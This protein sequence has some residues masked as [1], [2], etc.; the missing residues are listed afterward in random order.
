MATTTTWLVPE[1]WQSEPWYWRFSAVSHE[2]LVQKLVFFKVPAVV[3]L[4]K[5]GHGW[6]VVLRFTG[7]AETEVASLRVHVT[8]CPNEMQ[9]YMDQG[10]NSSGAVMICGRSDRTIVHMM[11]QLGS[12]FFGLHSRA[13]LGQSKPNLDRLLLEMGGYATTLRK[14]RACTNEL[15]WQ[16]MRRSCTPA[17]VLYGNNVCTDCMP[18]WLTYTKPTFPLP[19]KPV[20]QKVRPPRDPDDLITHMV[21]KLLNQTVQGLKNV[22]ARLDRLETHVKQVGDQVQK[23]DGRVRSLEGWQCSFGLRLNELEQ[24]PMYMDQLVNRVLQ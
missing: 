20:V 16:M 6:Y 19:D 21:N 5:E 23:L 4:A 2:V 1:R 7:M 3:V 8:S 12:R 22:E 24:R 10:S 18:K 9:L 11:K 15:W 14:Q 13:M 17:Q